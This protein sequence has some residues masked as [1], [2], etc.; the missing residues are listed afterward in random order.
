MENSFGLDGL[1]TVLFATPLELGL[2]E[3][4]SNACRMLGAACLGDLVQL[5]EAELLRTPNTGRK[6]VHEIQHALARFG[7]RL[8]MYLPEWEKVDAKA[9]RASEKNVIRQAVSQLEL[10]IDGARAASLQEEV[11][12][13]LSKVCGERNLA[14]IL[15]LWGFD[16]T[17]RKTLEQVGRAYGMTR[18]RVRQIEAGAVRKLQVRWHDMPLLDAALRTIE[19]SGLSR[20]DDLSTVLR[21]NAVPSTHVSASSILKAAEVFDREADIST[22]TFSSIPLV[23]APRFLRMLKRAILEL[24]RATQSSGCTSLTRIQFRLSGTIE[25]A[26]NLRRGFELLDEVVWLDPSHTWLYSNRPAR[27]RLSNLL[28][29]IFTVATRVHVSELRQAVSRPHR[30]KYV[31]P[32]DV[33]SAYCSAF[34]LSTTAENEI[35]S[36]RPLNAELGDLDGGFVRAFRTL[37]SPLTREEL[38]DYCVE[39]ERMKV[40]S[41]FQRLSYCPLFLRLASGVYG[42][43]GERSPP[44][45]VE[46]AKRRIREDR[47]P[48]Q[49]GWTR[50]GRLWVVLRLSRA[51]VHSG[52]FFVPS[53]VSDHGE[54]LWTTTLADGTP[55]G[56]MEIKQ[57]IA[58]GLRDEFDLLAADSGDFC[59][60]RFNLTKKDVSVEV[61]GPD[62]EDQATQSEAADT[63]DSDSDDFEDSFNEGD[64]IGEL[65]PGS[66]PG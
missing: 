13:A 55:I 37:G 20:S 44:G 1:N 16:G 19:Q 32:V 65:D 52:A 46:A 63:D 31:P 39:E 6:T 2:S 28:E 7:L 34:G 56:T 36:A 54:G 64:E 14:M 66:S 47:V 10:G 48:P 23:G 41:F 59:L 45:S 53:F 9:I 40:S 22:A 33:L 26:S 3:R 25:G 60:L 58:N 15:S 62:L 38:E 4:A 21:N 5:T 30:M 49:H 17:E 61:G 43:V 51:S 12:N 42:L 27:N 8:G 29:K 57:G 11:H 35:V 18:E 50:D 24:R